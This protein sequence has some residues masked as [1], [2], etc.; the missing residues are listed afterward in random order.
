MLGQIIPPAVP[1]GM[2][3]G[4]HKAAEVNFKQKVISHEDLPEIDLLDAARDAYVHTFDE[5]VYLAPE[6]RGKKEQLLSDGLDSTI[7]LTK[8]HR[9]EVAPQIQP[10]VDGV[11]KR[12]KID[13]GAD[14]PILGYIDLITDRN[15]IVDHKATKRSWPK[16]KIQ[17]DMQPVFYSIGYRHLTGDEVPPIFRFFIHVNLKTPKVQTQEH[18]VDYKQQVALIARIRTMI[19]MINKGVFPPA[20]PGDWVCSPRWCGYYQS[21]EFVGNGKPSTWV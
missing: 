21:C 8:L 3:R 5:G 11:E 20:N 17:K 12:F 4:L 15:E 1:M 9:R 14:L 13:I 16:G 10:K 6:E 7:S 2:G 18:I 19:A